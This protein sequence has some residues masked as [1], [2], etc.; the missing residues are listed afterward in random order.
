MPQVSSV[1][2]SLLTIVLVST[3]PVSSDML[4]GQWQQSDLIG[5]AQH[6]DGCTS[7]SY[8]TRKLTLDKEPGGAVTGI[9]S[10]YEQ[11]V[12]TLNA[13]S[14]CTF[15][16]PTM[17]RALFQRARMWPVQ[18]TSL[19]GRRWK[20]TASPSRCTGDACDD[21]NLWKSGFETEL[22]FEGET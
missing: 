14:Q 6:G 1:F 9:Y 21:P 11:A 7:L 18:A 8:L 13:Q 12:W 20:L 19:G 3:S 22:T 2:G 10:N 4:P 16:V 17:S 15:A 5:I